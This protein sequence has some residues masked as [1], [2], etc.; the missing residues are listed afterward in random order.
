MNIT[1]DSRK[2][3]KFACPCCGYK[4]VSASGGYD[5]C[6]VCF[7]EDDGQNDEDADVIRGG[8]NG[9]LN[10]SEARRNFADFGACEKRH[11][12][13]ARKPQHEEMPE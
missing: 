13:N 4:T 11:I 12:R 7:W 5:I 9:K 2:G 1:K 3:E 6:N 8:P 10:L